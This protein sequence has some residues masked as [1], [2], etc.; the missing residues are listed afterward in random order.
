MVSEKKYSHAR[1]RIKVVSTL[2]LVSAP[3]PC[4]V[5]VALS[6]ETFKARLEQTLGNVV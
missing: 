1:F 6:L 3:V 5:A 2:I 4:D